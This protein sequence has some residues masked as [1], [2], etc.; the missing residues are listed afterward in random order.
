MSILEH[1]IDFAA[2][3][4]V[5]HA[6]PNGDPLNG[7]RPREGYD[8][9]GEISDVCIKRK[10]RNRMMDLGLPV[11]VQSDDR[12]ID[13]YK[14][15]RDRAN[16]QSALK[17]AEKEKNS[18]VY[19]KVACEL[20]ADVRSF[21]QLFAVK[22]KQNKAE[23]KESG[24][25]GLSIGIRGPVSLHPAFSIAPIE[26]IETQIT[27]SVNGTTED[28]RGSDTMGMKY[29]VDRSVYVL[30][31]SISCQLAEKTGFTEEDAKTCLNTL[32]ENDLSSARPEGSM[33]VA[34][35]FW[36]THNCKAGQYST[37]QIHRAMTV[38]PIDAAPYYEVDLRPLDGLAL[39]HYV[40]AV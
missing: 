24:E 16:G 39:D 23:K 6:N 14:S 38:N 36:W 19:A 17:K 27:K 33:E 10:L 25:K 34:E 7:N 11:F 31:G 37:A 20:W 2:I 3:L 4:T 29:R 30:F 26:I 1:K 22:D 8:G 5:N 12:K 9:I 35:T 15:L 32:F 18:E 21:G 28:G 40:T 13:G